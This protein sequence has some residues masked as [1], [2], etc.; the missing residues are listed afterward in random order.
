MKILEVR[1]LAIAPR[2]AFDPAFRSWPLSAFGRLRVL[3]PDIGERPLP[4]IEAGFL[5]GVGDPRPTTSVA[6][7]QVLY[8]LA[9]L[10]TFH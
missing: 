6:A 4:Q 3:F 9:G 8:H 7:Y 2:V 10:A 5:Y 1:M